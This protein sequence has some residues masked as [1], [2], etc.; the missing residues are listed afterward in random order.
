MDAMQRLFDGINWHQRWEVQPGIF[1]P[2]GNSVADIMDWT[3]VPQSLAG[4]R[5]LDI[6][7][8]NG[9]FSFECERRGAAEVLAI[10]PE[11]PDN[12]GFTRLRQFLGSRVQYRLGTIYHL[13]PDEIGVFDIVLCF[14]VIYHLRYPLLGID[15]I[16]RVSRGD[17]HLET[18]ALTDAGQC[19][20]SDNSG[21]A[22]FNRIR[23]LL[24][25][26]QVPQPP[27]TPKPIWEFYRADEL[28]KD[29]SN[30]FSPN[31]QAVE[32]M[33]VSS[34]F[35]LLSISQH[36]NSRL[37]AHAR[38]APGRPEWLTIGSGEGVYYDVISKPVLG[39][40]NVY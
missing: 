31:K 28:N 4:K 7:A 12:S 17:L 6:G 21:T 16:R 29:P 30:W 13:Q 36:M 25:L 20:P 3:K 26:Q 14:G 34:G 24:R 37:A 19:G 9:C 39:D 33:L 32:E 38:V 35:T 10:G 2:G 27:A 18:H 1:T 22:V 40:I 15:M 11:H 23:S 8:W 5:V